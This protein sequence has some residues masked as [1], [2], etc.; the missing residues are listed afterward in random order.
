M[1]IVLIHQSIEVNPGTQHTLIPDQ[2]LSLQISV[3]YSIY[4]QALDKISQINIFKGF[5]RINEKTTLKGFKWQL[6]PIYANSSDAYLSNVNTWSTGL[7]SLL[8]FFLTLHYNMDGNAYVKKQVVQLPMIRPRWAY[9]IKIFLTEIDCE[10]FNR[11]LFPV[12]LLFEWVGTDR[13]FVSKVN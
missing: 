5:W 6:S 11:L 9:C 1:I 12:V 3:C 8:F 13:R 7:Q 4:Y 2:L 10:S